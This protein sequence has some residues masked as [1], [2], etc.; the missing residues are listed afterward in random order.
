MQESFHYYGT[1]C[2]AILAGYSHE[3]SLQVCYSAQLPDWCSR[4]FLERIGAPTAA[5]TTQLPAEMAQAGTDAL[6]RKDITRVWASFHFLPGDL[7]ADPGKGGKRYRNKFRM[8]CAPNGQLIADTVELARGKS[9][10]AVGLAMHVLAD[11]WAHRYFAGTPSLVINNTTS[12]YFVELKPDGNGGLMEWPVHFRHNSGASDDLDASEYT[13]T[14]YQASENSVMNLGHGRAGH[15]PDLSCVRYKYVPAWANY[16]EVVKDNPADYYQAFT[17]MVYA[18]RY[19]RGD[20]ASFALDTYDTDSIAEWDETIR[21][22][23]EKRQ[24]ES[25]ALEDWHALAER[26]SGCEV[27]PFDLDAYVGEY[28]AA[29]AKA[30]EGTFLGKFI[31]AALAQKGMVVNRVFSSGNPLAGRSVSYDEHGFAGMRDFLPLV[32]YLR[33][34]ERDE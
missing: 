1:Y 12:R 26:M 34:G 32:G 17:Q 16:E 3:E 23:L 9:L 10:Q 31:L 22:L 11:T 8:I 6:G 2:A 24:P 14:I 13:N 28:E 33:G 15:L 4:V 20:T 21:T 29:P 19:L 7:H 5:A 25:G 18:L 30:K 27:A